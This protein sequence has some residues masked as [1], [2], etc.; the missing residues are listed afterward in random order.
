MALKTKYT[1]HKRALIKLNDGESERFG[2]LKGKEFLP[3]AQDIRSMIAQFQL[4]GN[5]T[6]ITSIDSVNQHLIVTKVR[7]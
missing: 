4:D 5:G 1:N 2:A 7:H 6:Y 3:S